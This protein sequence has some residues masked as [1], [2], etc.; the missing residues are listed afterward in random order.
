ML[1]KTYLASILVLIFTIN[2]E[3]KDN[4]FI[5]LEMGYA[6]STFD[7]S[8]PNTGIETESTTYQQFKIGKYFDTFRVCI[9]LDAGKNIGAG[10]DYLINMNNSKFTPYIGTGLYYTSHDFKGGD[11]KG[12]SLPVVVG[13]LYKIDD[14]FDFEFG[15]RYIFDTYEYKSSTLKYKYKNGQNYFVG[16]NYNF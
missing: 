4:V 8:T 9:D 16:I 12:I 15:F 11:A 2:M 14:K 7:I 6:T 13:S 5:G 10:F 3:A 1:K